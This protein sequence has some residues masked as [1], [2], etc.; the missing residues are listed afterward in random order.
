MKTN[1]KKDK[2][3]TNEWP[4]PLHSTTQS[5]KSLICILLEKNRFLYQKLEEK[6]PHNFGFV[7][8]CFLSSH[9]TIISNIAP[10]HTAFQLSIVI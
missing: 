10:K 4:L 5:F 2:N 8:I 7:A 1:L 9:H 6:T 3:K